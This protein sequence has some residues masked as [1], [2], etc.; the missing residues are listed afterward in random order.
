M[1]DLVKKPRSVDDYLTPEG[2]QQAL[3]DLSFIC[4]AHQRGCKCPYCEAVGR[5]LYMLKP[6]LHAVIH[7]SGC[8]KN[9][10]H[11]QT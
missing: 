2:L 1:T 5:I 11:T 3:T 8:K 4:G 6:P 9:C 7:H 10:F